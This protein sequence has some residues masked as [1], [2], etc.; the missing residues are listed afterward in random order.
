V[1]T[2]VSEPPTA[3]AWLG[4]ALI[5]LGAIVLVVGLLV[6]DSDAEASLAL[7]VGPAAVLVAA[8]AALV[9]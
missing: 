2:P 8:G 7:V 4:C 5:V 6:L 3:R 1:K 9:R